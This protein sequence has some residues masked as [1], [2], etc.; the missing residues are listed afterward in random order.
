L[1][2]QFKRWLAAL[3]SGWGRLRWQCARFFQQLGRLFGLVFWRLGRWLTFRRSRFLLQ[4]LPAV[5]G[6]VGVGVVAGMILVNAQDQRVLHYQQQGA[7][8]LQAGNAALAQ[9]CYERLAQLDVNRPEFRFLLALAVQAQGETDYREGV[10]LQ[11]AGD[12]EQA[13]NYADRARTHFERAAALMGKLASPNAQGHAPAHVW[14][15]QRLIATRN[16]TALKDGELHLRRALQEQPDNLAANALIGQL[17]LATNRL[18]QAELPLRKALPAQPAL[19]LD[20]ARLYAA[21]GNKDLAKAHGEKARQHFNDQAEARIDNHTARIQWHEACLFLGDFPA[22]ARVL[23]EG[24]RLSSNAAY[25]PALA[26]VFVLWSDAVARLGKTDAPDM[27][28]PPEKAPKIDE[29]VRLTSRIGLLERALQY[30]FGNLTALA[31]LLELTRSGDPDEAEKARATLRTLLA[32]GKHP[33][34]IHLVMGMDAQRSGKIPEARAHFEQAYQLSPDMPILINNLAWTMAF[35]EKPELKE[36]LELIESAL[37]RQPTNP[38]F[39]ETRG[40]VLARMGK[41]EEALPDLEAGLRVMAGNRDLHRALA[42]T[43]RALGNHAMADEHRR[44]AERGAPEIVGPPA[45]KQ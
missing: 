42:E 17:Y 9:L 44:V 29:G 25:R 8:A 3:R 4:G 16:P 7:A 19:N 43:Y 27:K 18:E 23:E 38:R 41:Y 40:Q 21:R 33:A 2:R 34:T 10:K 11:Q 22:A 35:A 20:L 37:K 15:A 13:K 5:L 45:P 14:W 32:A 31:R 12:T 36:A 1:R 28:E 39:R 24:L 30:D 6:I 26:R